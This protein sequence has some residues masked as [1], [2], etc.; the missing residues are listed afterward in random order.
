MYFSRNS[1]RQ[2]HRGHQDPRKQQGRRVRPAAA[3][4]AERETRGRDSIRQTVKTINAAFINSARENIQRI[5]LYRI[6][7]SKCYGILI[8]VIFTG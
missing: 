6:Q 4:Q 8:Q 7:L 5:Q 3:G 2:R 1:T